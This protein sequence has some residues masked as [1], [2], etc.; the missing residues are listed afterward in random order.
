MSGSIQL[1]ITNK[2]EVYKISKPYYSDYKAVPSLANQEILLVIL[3]YKTVNRKPF[4][5]DF[6]SF[7]RDTLDKDGVLKINL[8][9]I[10]DILV[11]FNSPKELASGSEPILLPQAP[12]NVPT[13]IEKAALY[14][15]I[16]DR[17][18]TLL[19]NCSYLVEQQIKALDEIFKRH[20]DFVKEAFKIRNNMD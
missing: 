10:K 13:S 19:P 4:E 17:Y 15:Y 8:D 3:S 16:K 14:S 9:H 5:L 11:Y 2:G 12:N 1:Y 18:P 20:K 7:H 6:V